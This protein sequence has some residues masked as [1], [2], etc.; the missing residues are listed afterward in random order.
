MQA[1][2]EADVVVALYNPRSRGRDWQLG[3]ALAILGAHR[4]PATPVG[5]VRNAT[6]PG[7][8]VTVTTLADVDPA[9]VDMLTVVIVGSSTT[10]VVDGPH[11]DAARLPVAGVRAVHPI[12][13]E[14]YRILRSRVDTSALPY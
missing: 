13:P 5:L 6:R 10:R 2:A 1:A 14:S 7:E 11:R 4:P 12:E 8:R 9:T 3:K